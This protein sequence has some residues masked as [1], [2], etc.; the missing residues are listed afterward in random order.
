MSGVAIP[1]SPW[2]ELWTRVPRRERRHVVVAFVMGMA[3]ST[4]AVGVPVVAGAAVDRLTD[5]SDATTTTWLV[6]AVVALAAGKAAALRVR[7]YL[8]FTSSARF[9]GHLRSGLYASLHERDARFFDETPPGEVLGAFG[10]DS[11]YVE[12]FAISVQVLLNNVV[13]T[14]LIVAVLVWIDLPLALVALAPLPLVLVLS[15]RFLA[16]LR[17]ADAA[18][19]R[20][21]VA[22][23]GQVA[24]AVTGAAVVK[25]LGLEDAF[26]R[27]LVAASD[28]SRAS[29]VEVGRIRAR[30]TALIEL[31][32]TVSIAAVLVVGAARIGSGDLTIGEFTAFNAYVVMA[33]WPLRFTA[34]AVSGASR[35]RLAIGRIAGLEGPTRPRRRTD[36]PR[37][38]AP[39]PEQAAPVSLRLDGVAFAYGAGD[40][41]LEGVDLHVAPGELVAITGATGSGKTTLLRL[42]SGERAPDRGTV[43]VGGHRLA[44]VAPRE[45]ARLVSVVSDD[46]FLFS[47]SLRDNL[48]MAHP[49]AADEALRTVTSLAVLDDVVA[50]MPQGWD[51]LVGERAAR[52]SGGQR[53]R[54][55]LARGLL[56]PAGLLL[57]DDVTSALDQETRAAFARS[58]AQVRRDR[59]I[60]V[61]TAQPELIA[62]AD[63][64]LVLTDKRLTELTEADHD[65]RAD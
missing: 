25:G 15:V 60:V 64:V 9:G 23:V 63:R 42:I 17:V 53:Q 39:W 31:V 7:R 61:V 35:A 1:A 10:D 44:D 58:M 52:L 30:Y 33:V 5:G 56:A 36:V 51:T 11:E 4:A 6:V 47:R 38:D 22:I 54:T 40:A 2:R 57:L 43:V 45:R 32:P 19:R 65:P 29:A 21:S 24:D 48:R 12:Q 46:E 14:G 3:W 34:N 27:R 41:V 49:E 62:A 20:E 26:V 18:L 13:W 55:A 16:A 50:R 8:T 28:R 37:A 59:T